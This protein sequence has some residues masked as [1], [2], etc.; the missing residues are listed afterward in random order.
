MRVQRHAS[1]LDLEHL[2]LQRCPTASHPHVQECLLDLLTTTVV[3][4]LP[5]AETAL[6]D[7]PTATVVARLC[8]APIAQSTAMLMSF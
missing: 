5:Q 2:L 1:V 7:A 4:G 8:A 3:L 6:R